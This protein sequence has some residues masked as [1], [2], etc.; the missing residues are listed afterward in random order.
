MSVIVRQEIIATIVRVCPGTIDARNRWCRLPYFSRYFSL[1]AP[2][3]G[4]SSLLCGRRPRL[5]PKT[6]T[7]AAKLPI[8]SDAHFCP[9]PQTRRPRQIPLYTNKSFHVHR[10]SKNQFFFLKNSFRIEAFFECAFARGQFSSTREKQAK[11]NV[12]HL[13][14]PTIGKCG[15]SFAPPRRHYKTNRSRYKGSPIYMQTNNF[16]WKSIQPRL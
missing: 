6:P 13:G 14:S 5:V 7:A 4:L 12:I 8:E 2:P 15:G 16:I 3:D 9:S 1:C 11:R 10:F